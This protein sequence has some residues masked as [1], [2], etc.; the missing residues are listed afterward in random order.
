MR[1]NYLAAFMAISISS[2]AQTNTYLSEAIDAASRTTGIVPGAV[3]VVEGSFPLPSVGLSLA[4]LPLQES[5]DGVSM[6]LTPQGGGEPFKAWMVYTFASRSGQEAAAVL[7]SAT[8]PGEYDLTLVSGSTTARVG[9]AR[10]VR[11]KYRS[12]STGG[13]GVGQAVIQNRGESEPFD[14]NM[15]VAGSF[16]ETAASTGTGL[17]IRNP[18]VDTLHGGLLRSPAKPGQSVTLWGTR[19]RGDC[20]GG[21]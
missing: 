15:F 11:C 12:L 1:W 9:K 21:Q 2:L 10:V 8:P 14:V 6:T 3:F 19:P 20:G 16:G 4:S 18:W 7:P 13:A 5:L 17:P